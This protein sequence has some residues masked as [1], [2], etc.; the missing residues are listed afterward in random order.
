MYFKVIMEM[1][2][3]GS[4]KSFEI[5]RFFEAEDAMMLMSLLAN[6]PALKSKNSMSSVKLIKPISKEEFERG[7]IKQQAY[8][9][10]VRLFPRYPINEKCVIDSSPLSPYRELKIE[11]IATAE[12]YS[13]SGA[14][15]KYG[16]NE[17]KKGDSFSV[18]IK[19]LNI[20][21][22]EAKVA[23]SSFSNG[24]SMSGLQWL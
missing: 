4:G 17:L 12:D 6:Y 14:S 8:S 2:H 23:W 11:L 9:Y 1:G 22:K 19:S 24:I 21:K 3:L 18:T 20:V 10:N 16:F 15:I 5:I 7:K 13:K